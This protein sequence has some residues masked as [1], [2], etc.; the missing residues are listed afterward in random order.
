MEFGF[1]KLPWYGRLG[2]CAIVSWA[3]V[4]VFHL[5]WVAPQHAQLALRYQQLDDARREVLSARQR[6]QALGEIEE[7][8]VRSRARFDDLRGAFPTAQDA[9]GLLRRLQAAT[10]AFG[11]SLRAVTPQPVEPGEVY[12]RWPTRL[13]IVGTYHD[14]GAFL[15]AVRT[16]APLMAIEDVT[17]DAVVPPQ[18]DATIRVTCTASVYVLEEP[19]AD[20]EP[21]V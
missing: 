4:L 18:P 5:S 11:L 14:L 17:L 2:V 3:G 21:V 6:A 15:A 8:V 19:V 1:D 16:S 9:A 20:G 12:A 10:T 13:E 7:D